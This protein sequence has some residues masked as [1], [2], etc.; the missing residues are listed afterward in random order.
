M[1]GMGPD[2]AMHNPYSIMTTTFCCCCCCV[3]SKLLMMPRPVRP[4]SL[5]DVL[6]N[7]TNWM[8]VDRS[9]V[10]FDGTQCDKVGTSFTAFRYHSDRCKRAP[11]VRHEP[12]C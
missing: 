5:S 11:Q 7:R 9:M 12:V 2:S 1:V 4:Q 6:G 3:S 10:S 8:L